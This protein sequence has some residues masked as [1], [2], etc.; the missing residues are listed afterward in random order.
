MSDIKTHRWFGELDWDAL[1]QKKVPATYRPP[2]K[3]K[4]DTSNYSTYPD[5]TDLPKAIKSSDD[6]FINW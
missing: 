3:G 4:N 2:V 1:V 6:P 5:S